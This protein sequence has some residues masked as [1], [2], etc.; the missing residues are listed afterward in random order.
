VEHAV[1]ERVAPLQERVDFLLP[2]IASVRTKRC[3]V[4]QSAHTFLLAQR[5]VKPVERA[6]ARCW[7]QGPRAQFFSGFGGHGAEPLLAVAGQQTYRC[8]PHAMFLALFIT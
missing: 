3:Y 8:R 7:L 4:K 5:H 2:H 1:E 6:H